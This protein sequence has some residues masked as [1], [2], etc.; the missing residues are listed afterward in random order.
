[1]DAPP[2]P[3]TGYRLS[4]PSHADI[5]AVAE[6]KRTVE[7]TRHGDSDVTVDDLI[8]EWALPRVSMTEDL[9]IV[10]TSS[11]DIV[12]YGFVWQEDPPCVFVAE[13]TVHPDH[14]EH[15]LSELLLRLAETRARQAGGTPPAGRQINLG[16][17]THEGDARRIALFERHGYRHVRSFLRLELDLSQ[18]S[19]SPAWPAGIEVRHFRRHRDEEAVHAAMDEAFRDHWRPDVMSLEEWLAFRFERPGLDLGLWWVAWAGNEVAG[20]AL[21]IETPLGGYVADLAVR[22][23]WRGCGLGRALLLQAFAELRRRGQQ[24]A[25]L[26]V[27]RDNPTG[28]M[29]LYTSL[30]MRPVRGAH[31]VF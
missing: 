20:A 28:A 12:G 19:A 14:R 27:D 31:Q 10:E 29:H 13:Q 15:G 7:L 8:E 3:P 2:T 6:L 26:G 21:A 1:M 16:V 17:W 5:R 24:R 23:P 11:G 25:Y 18:P 22:R 9:W 30:G 4:R